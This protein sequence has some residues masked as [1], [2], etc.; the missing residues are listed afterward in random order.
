VALEGEGEH[1]RA[2]L[3]GET[4]GL[5]EL[6][7]DITLE[8][9]FDQI[10]YVLVD[11]KYALSLAKVEFRSERRFVWDQFPMTIDLSGVLDANSEF[12]LEVDE[13]ISDVLLWKRKLGLWTLALP[14]HVESKS[15]L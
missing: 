10:S 1:L 13:D 15:L 12:L 4:E 6:T 3:K 5:R 7:E 11:S 14:S 9:D 8:G 2:S